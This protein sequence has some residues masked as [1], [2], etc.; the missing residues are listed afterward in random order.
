[1]TAQDTMQNNTSKASSTDY[2]VVV[3]GAGFSGLGLLHYLKQQ[4]LSVRVF[5]KA[6]NIG[7]TWT[8]NRYPGARGDSETYYY[9]FTFSQELLQEWS[10]SERYPAWGEILEYL[11]FLADRCNLMPDIQLE[12]TIESAIYDNESGRWIVRTS[13]GDTYTC[14]YFVSAM[15]LISEPYIPEIKGLESFA[16]PCFHSA[17]WPKEGLD[18][19]GK[20]VGIIGAGATAVQLVPSMAPDAESVTLFQQ[21]PNYILPARQRKMT[22]EWEKEIKSNYPEII[23]KC[24]NHVFGMPFDSPVDRVAADSTEE[25]QNA[26]YQKLWEE[27]GFRFCFESYDDLLENLDANETAANFLRHKITELVDDPETAEMLTPRGYPLFAKRPPLDHGYYEAFNRDNVHLVDIAKT[28]PIVEVTETGVLTEK[29]LYEFDIIILATGFDALTGAL[30]YMEIRGASG[31]TLKE[32]WRA[33]PSTFMGVC[34]S[35]FPNLFMITGPQAPF[36]NLPTT[37]EENIKWISACIKHMES[38]NY[39]SMDVSENAEKQWGDHAAEVIDLTVMKYGH[40]AN[41]WFVG[42]NIPGKGPSTLVYFGGA[43][44]YFDK[45]QESLEKKFPELN[46][47]ATV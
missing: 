21:T 38:Q 3:I 11:H 22:P 36:A 26:I 10:W 7:G 27:G 32:K 43:N 25:E 45:L 33:G 6:D 37:I 18:Y 30:E 47:T 5:D 34:S 17:R 14:K 1:M 31:E 28:E 39:A 35:G 41:S 24:R 40:E 15:G 23:N 29:Q 44:N 42:S 20:R 2:D 46:F 16:G 12:T 8:W 13:S 4:D 19:S 9:C